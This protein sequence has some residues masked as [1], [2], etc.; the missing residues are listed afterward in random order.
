MSNTGHRKPC[1]QCKKYLANVDM[2]DEGL[3]IICEVCGYSYEDRIDFGE[4]ALKES[5]FLRYYDGGSDMGGRPRRK[6]TEEWKGFGASLMTFRNKETHHSCYPLPIT[7]V[8]IH[9]FMQT[10]CFPDVDFAMC[11][12]TRWNDETREV[13]IILGREELVADLLV[14]NNRWDDEIGDWIG[15]EEP[16]PAEFDELLEN[17]GEESRT[18]NG[19]EA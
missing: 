12:L 10:I 13:E 18:E 6:T 16:F 4:D 2:W 7:E 15:Q 19:H 14:E 3:I 9:M 11:Y 8:L 17:M 1:P 5:G